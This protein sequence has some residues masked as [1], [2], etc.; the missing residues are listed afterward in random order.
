MPAN[1]H[2]HSALDLAHR[3]GDLA[4]NGAWCVIIP[5]RL[6]WVLTVEDGA[7][8]LILLHPA[9]SLLPI[10]YFLYLV[11]S[12]RLIDCFGSGELSGA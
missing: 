3:K 7:K 6:H 4:T 12:H 8:L 9:V 10:W 5:K 1:G 2:P 11:T